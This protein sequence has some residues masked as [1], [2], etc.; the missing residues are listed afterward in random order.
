MGFVYCISCVQAAGPLNATQL[1]A[2]EIIHSF[3]HLFVYLL[4]VYKSNNNSEQR[5]GQDIKATR[6]ALITAHCD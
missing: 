1:Q 5:V 6:D 3:I 4:K 2:A